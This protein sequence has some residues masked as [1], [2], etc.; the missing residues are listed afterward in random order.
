MQ[1]GVSFAALNA[2]PANGVTQARPLPGFANENVDADT[3]SS[4][5]NAMQVQVRHNMGRLNYEFNYTWSHEIDNLVNVFSGW[6]DP[7]NPNVDRGDGDWDVRQ[8]LTG[9]VVYQF[10]DFKGSSG[11]GKAFLSGWQGS[12]IFQTRSGLPVNVQLISGFFGLPIR[13]NY[14]PGQSTSV[15]GANWPNGNYNPGAFVVPPG[16]NGD[17]G[18]PENIGTVG[19]NALRGPAFF[20]W[21]LSAMKNIPLKE[22]IQLQFRADVFNILNHPNFANPD[23]GICNAVI[24]ASGSTPASCVPNPNFGRTGQTNRRQHGHADRNRHGSPDPARREGDFLI[25]R[26]FNSAAI[27]PYC[28]HNLPTFSGRSCSVITARVAAVRRSVFS[29][30][31]L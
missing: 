9:S 25:A 24:P 18:T 2:N 14:V 5:Y 30:D 4:T 21:D 6:S 19:R 12:S 13:P 28:R 20:Q 27:A 26:M 15:G 7:F 31:P 11:W 8:N 23:G 17:W 22:G 10:P 29:F 1:A 3:L 16:Y